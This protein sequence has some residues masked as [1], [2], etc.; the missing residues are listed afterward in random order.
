M[1]LKFNIYGLFAGIFGLAGCASY[2]L[3]NKV[4]YPLSV[5]KGCL[6]AENYDLRLS[7]SVVTYTNA[8]SFKTRTLEIGTFVHGS[9]FDLTRPYLVAMDLNS[10]GTINMVDVVY[11][12]VGNPLQ[13]LASVGRLS[14]LEKRLMNKECSN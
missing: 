4:V 5:S 14:E 13:S 12:P 9:R 2:N 10:D 11:V 6:S 1:S 8:L 7:E 3:P